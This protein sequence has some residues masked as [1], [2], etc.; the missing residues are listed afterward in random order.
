MKPVYVCSLMVEISLNIL[1]AMLL[2]Y[3]SFVGKRHIAI[4]SFKKCPM[5]KDEKDCKSFEKY[6][7]YSV[8]LLIYVV[9]ECKYY[10]C[11]AVKQQLHV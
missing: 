11:L 5:I 4:R 1:L 10:T 9:P 6:V 8:S 7:K 2:N 3:I